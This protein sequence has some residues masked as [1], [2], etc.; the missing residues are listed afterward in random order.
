MIE[1]CRRVWQEFK[2][3]RFLE[4][5]NCS[6]W[7]VYNR[8]TDPDTAQNAL[9][10]VE[11]YHGYP[12][13]YMFESTDLD[14]NWLETLTDMKDWCYENCRGKWRSDIH[15]VHK[16]SDIHA[17]VYVLNELGGYDYLFV[18]FKDQVDHNWFVLRWGK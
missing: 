3:R 2:D 12:Y 10:I 8:Q 17:D 16:L 1:Y 5:N 6:S 11:W 9:H 13:I 4:R 14:G 18:A 7:E 15:R